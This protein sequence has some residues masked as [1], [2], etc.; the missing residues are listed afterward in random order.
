MQSQGTPGAGL[1]TA[2]AEMA[3]TISAVVIS[4]FMALI[5][6]NGLQGGHRIKNTL[7]CRCYNKS[8]RKLLSNTTK[9]MPP[10]NCRNH[11]LVMA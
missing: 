8:V 9:Y 7:P 4:F 2:N 3:L 1:T 6:A 5:F 11:V 10:L